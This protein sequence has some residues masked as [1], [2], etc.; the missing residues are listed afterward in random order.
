MYRIVTAIVLVI[1]VVLPAVAQTA[2]PATTIVLTT[3]GVR[4]TIPGMDGVVVLAESDRRLGPGCSVL[5]RHE[6][7]DTNPVAWRASMSPNTRGQMIAGP[8]DLPL[9]CGNDGRLSFDKVDVPTR[10]VWDDTPSSQVQ[11]K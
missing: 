6:N 9:T 4:F 3:F 5:I 10:W 11:Y 8:L 7:G 2:S 1:G